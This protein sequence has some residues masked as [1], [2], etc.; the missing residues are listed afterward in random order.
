MTN[1]RPLPRTLWKKIWVAVRFLIFGV[2]GFLL[3]FVSWVN[4]VGRFVSTHHESGEMNPFL[5][6]FLSFLGALMMLFG[7]GEWGRWAYL[8]VFLSIP[9]S[10]LL[11]FLLPHSGK[12]VGVLVPTLA[13]VGTL[14]IVR[15]YYASKNRRNLNTA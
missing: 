12:D 6:A 14:I 9:V 7:V 2:F 11:L 4:L 13:A 8:L 15:R 10:L 5:L 1:S 3:M